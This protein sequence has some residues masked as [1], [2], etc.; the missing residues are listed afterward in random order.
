MSNNNKFKIAFSFALG[1]VMAAEWLE[2]KTGFFNITDMFDFS[3]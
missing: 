3:I 1:A 2:E